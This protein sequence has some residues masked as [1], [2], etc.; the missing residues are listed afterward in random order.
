MVDK[1]II[2]PWN[3]IQGKLTKKELLNSY[4]AVLC[5]LH[6]LEIRLNMFKMFHHQHLVIIVSCC[7]VPC[8]A[9]PALP[10]LAL[11]GNNDN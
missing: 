8:L 9:W 2:G 4:P 1:M 11:P 7:A 6:C 10:C 3:C 5:R